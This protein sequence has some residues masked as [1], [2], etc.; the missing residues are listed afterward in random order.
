MPRTMSVI[1]DLPEDLE[2]DA[3]SL[4][5]ALALFKAAGRAVP[6]PWASMLARGE[7]IRSGLT[8]ANAAL[9]A[10]G[11]GDPPRERDRLPLP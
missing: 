6:E 1:H 11:A 4:R 10:Q 2:N 3:G 8:I 9:R 5:A 7:R